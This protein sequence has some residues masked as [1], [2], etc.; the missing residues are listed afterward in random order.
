MAGDSAN[1]VSSFP[2]GDLGRDIVVAI[3]APNAPMDH[4]VLGTDTTPERLRLIAAIVQEK[5]C[6]SPE[7]RILVLATAEDEARLRGFLRARSIEGISLDTYRL[8][9]L[10][11]A[12]PN[13]PFR[14]GTVHVA[15]PERLEVDA[16]QREVSRGDWDLLFVIEAASSQTP[17]EPRGPLRSDKMSISL[18]AQRRVIVTP[19]YS[20]SHFELE[21]RVDFRIHNLG[22]VAPQSAARLRTLPYE[23]T[24]ADFQT[25]D[26]LYQ[27]LPIANREVASSQSMLLAFMLASAA[28]SS[29]E[30][31]LELIDVLIPA[32]G[33]GLNFHSESSLDNLPDWFQAAARGPKIQLGVTDASP[34]LDLLREIK[35]QLSI[36]NGD[37]KRQAIVR[38]IAEQPGKP[39]ICVASRHVPSLYSLSAYLDDHQVS[40]G[41]VICETGS[42]TTR[43]EVALAKAQSRGGVVLAT[44]ESLDQV[45]LQGIQHVIWMDEG[46]VEDSANFLS[47]HAPE[48]ISSSNLQVWILSGKVWA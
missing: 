26:L 22:G 25:R 23:P 8:R 1:A 16:F 9:E 36:M 17:S 20:D 2:F 6:S 5:L 45:S 21:G 39:A 40:H 48:G 24:D 42:S 37:L 30:A 15:A 18:T 10:I 19:N 32:L 3:L 7:S 29:P 44:P 4:L 27:L 34:L 14:P 47:A 38:F 41:L 28:G 35:H 46:A 13:Q 12:N 33:T 43:L 31:A 11:D